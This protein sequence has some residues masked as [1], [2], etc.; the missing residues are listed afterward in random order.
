MNIFYLDSDPVKCAEYHNDKHCVKMIVETAQLLSSAH[1]VLD[2]NKNIIKNTSGR[3]QTVWELA[4]DIDGI[5]YKATHVNHPSARWA[6]AS[7]ANYLW[8]YQLFSALAGEYKY[9]FNKDHMSWVKLAD[10]L[11]YPPVNISNNHFEEPYLALPDEY[12]KYNAVT[13]YRM[14]Y[15]G[16]KR[17]LAKWSKRDK[18]EWF[19]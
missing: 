11:K 5:V 19:I 6:R 7:R 17:H 9:R 14:C 2:G 16:S 12:R 18:P 3:K 15:M 10:I 13:A 4:G 8:L 1:R